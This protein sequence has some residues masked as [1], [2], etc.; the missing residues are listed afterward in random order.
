MKLSVLLVLL[1]GLGFQATYAQTA[2]EIVAK[3]F[4]ALGG[5]EKWKSLKNSKMSATLTMQ[6][7]E[8]SATMFSAEPNKSR[9]EINVMGQNIIQACD[10]ATA[11]MINPLQGSGDPQVMPEELAESLKN[12]DFHS[13][14]LDY[15]AKESKLELEGKETVEGTDCFKLKLT[16]KDGRLEYHL[17]DAETFVPIMTRTVVKSGPAAGQVVE[18]FVSDYQE[19]EGLMVPFFIEAKLAGQTT[20]KVTIK[21]VKFNQPVEDSLFA[22]PK[23]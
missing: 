13:G 21:E 16:K 19:V 20:Q 12:Q 1:L 4:E 8:F 2:D 23:K 17:I 11:W 22:F 10:G 3:S 15:A 9:A 14:L 6:G 7:M 18:T 5:A